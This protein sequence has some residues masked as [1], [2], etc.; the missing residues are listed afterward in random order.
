MN[1]STMN[2]L[3]YKAIKQK[4]IFHDEAKYKMKRKIPKDFHCTDSFVVTELLIRYSK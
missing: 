4:F 2:S 3:Y 1:S